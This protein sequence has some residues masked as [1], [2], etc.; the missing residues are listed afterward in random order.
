MAITDYFNN[1]TVSTRPDAAALTAQKLIGAAS[2]TVDTTAGWPQS[3][4]AVHFVIYQVDASG[5]RVAG[6]QTEWKGIV[7]SATAIGSLTLKAGTD[8]VYP[9]GSKVI[10][11]PTAAWADD[12]V[13]G[14]LVDHSQAGAHEFTTV[15]DP[16]NPT[17]ETLKLAGV[18][19][20]VNEITVTN[21]ATGT[22]PTITATGGDTNVGLEFAPKGTGNIF[23]THLYD[24]QKGSSTWTYASS[25]TFTVPQSDA[26]L[27][28]T[29]TK[30]W[31]TQT[32]SKYFYVV[33]KSG[34]TITVSGGS[35]YSVANA[36]ITA[37]YFSNAKSPVGFPQYFNYTPTFANTT[38][39]NGTVTGRFEMDGKTVKA[40][41]LFTLGSTSAIGTGPTCTLPITST[42]TQ[43]TNP[44][45]RIG[46][47][48]INDSG[49][50]TYWGPVRWISTTVCDPVVWN[51]GSTYLVVNGISA[52]VPIAAP[53]TGDS[54]GMVFEY[55]AA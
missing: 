54:L 4:D 9:I 12:M 19:S 15:Y 2:I 35:D 20:A 28:T 29:G 11:T 10:A 7:T 6:T 36:A 41:T 39:G 13:T 27:M 1:A 37:P 43:Y 5:N 38:L 53:T 24:W 46:D 52:T 31:L 30:I 33:S 40:R 26:D 48:T 17:L 44:I 45:T 8:Q 34:T 23:F 55:E 42:S 47:C 14:L 21:A 3:T 18:A 16:S 49:T 25:T 50:A 22:N 51:A 32:T